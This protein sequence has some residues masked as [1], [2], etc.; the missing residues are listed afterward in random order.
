MKSVLRSIKPY[1]LY[2]IITGR[3]TVE[4]GKDFPISPEWDRKVELYCSKDKKSFKR[5]P[6]ADREWMRKY[7]GKVACRFVCDKDES[8]WFYMDTDGTPISNIK[9]DYEQASCLK[10]KE[11]IDYILRPNK[12]RN[13]EKGT[14][15]VHGWH[16]SDLKIYDT[17]KE[18]GEFF[19]KGECENFDF[20]PC[21]SNFHKGRGWLDGSTCDEDDCI[22][23]GIKPITR[24]P[25]SWQ[26]TEAV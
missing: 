1:Y 15:W 17:P 20:C 7:L 11:I 8:R 19:I 13:A 25:Q 26:Y 21:C 24:P 23:Y 4:L 9:S 22:T 12:K 14:N 16:V 2:L 5:I 6:E 10:R 18:L 3:K